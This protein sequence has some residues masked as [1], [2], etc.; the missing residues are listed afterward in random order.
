MKVI[1]AGRPLSSVAITGRGEECRWLAPSVGSHDTLP[2]KMWSHVAIG[3]RATVI[4][5]M[6]WSRVGGQADLT[7]DFVCAEEGGSLVW[8]RSIA[9]SAT[10][11]DW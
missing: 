1:I 11:R 2:S 5:Q 3:A 7:L 10:L 4:A 6:E 8:Q 9:G